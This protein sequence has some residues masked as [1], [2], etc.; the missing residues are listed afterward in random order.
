MKEKI[1]KINQYILKKMFI[2]FVIE[3]ILSLLSSV[4]IMKILYNV[5]YS[6]QQQFI[7]NENYDCILLLILFLFCIMYFIILIIKSCKDKLEK[8]FLAIAIPISIAY[9]IFVIPGYVPD[10]DAHYFRAYE[11][12]TGKLICDTNEQM[13]P[14][15]EIPI[16]I[17]NFR[18]ENI[19]NYYELRDKL[20]KEVNYEQ[21]ESI[22]N[23]TQCYFPVLYSASALG[24][25]FA[26]IFNC[27]IVITLYMARS[28]NLIL[29]LIMGYYSIKLMPFGKITAFLYLLT[30]MILHQAASISADSLVNSSCLLYIAYVLFLTFKDSKI[31]LNNSIILC[32]FSILLGF[33]KTVYCP[34][35][36]LSILLIFRKNKNEQKKENIILVISCVLICL[37]IAFAWY[38][39]TTQFHDGRTDLY[40]NNQTKCYT[41]QDVIN[42][43]LDFLHKLKK[44][45]DKSFV[46]YIKEFLGISLGWLNITVHEG[47]ILIYL[48]LLVISPFL[49]KHNNELSKKQKL[50]LFMIFLVTLLLIMVALYIGWTKDGEEIIDGVQGRYFIPI[51]ILIL[52]CMCYKEKNVQFKN[53]YLIMPLCVSMVHFV[54]IRSII[55]AFIL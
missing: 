7:L 22:F 28:F 47:S 37:I 8:I 2:F 34:L 26:R 9:M 43:P 33:A 19:S 53:L 18:K 4:I 50:I 29:F 23:A 39:F 12:S 25:L 42:D 48:V 3:F 11:I 46:T 44:T 16:A 54:A 30:P 13:I 41:L 1:K 5:Y 17:T 32:V 31:T 49:E 40:E 45:M 55:K 38:N 21:K 35:V 24:M 10:E 14:T 52:L 20:N 51:I 27:S 6:V 36:L 15:S